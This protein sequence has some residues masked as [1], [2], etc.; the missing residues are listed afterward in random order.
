MIDGKNPRPSGRGV[1]N[2]GTSIICFSA[3]W[4]RLRLASGGYIY[5]DWHRY[6]GPT[7]YSD[8]AGN[9]YID[10]W[11]ENPEIC[12]ALDWFQNRGNRA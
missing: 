1:I 6:L 11:W 4:F 3:G 5:M 10:E 2:A 9:R 12:E 7:F 8:R